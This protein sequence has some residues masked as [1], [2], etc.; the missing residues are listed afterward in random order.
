MGYLSWI[1]AWLKFCL[2]EYCTCP[3][4]SYSRQWCNCGLY[5]HENSFMT[6]NNKAEML[7]SHNLLRNHQCLDLLNPLRPSDLI[8]CFWFL[9]SLLQ[10]FWSLLPQVK[11]RC[12]MALS[13]Y[14]KQ[15]WHIINWTLEN[16]FY[17]NFNA[18][19]DIF[20][21]KYHLN[22]SSAKWQPFCFHCWDDTKPYFV[23]QYDTIT[24]WP[25]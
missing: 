6:Q 1:K 15:W 17:W 20:C 4:L 16:K 19:T 2:D 7:R 21:R 5:F 8:W 14:L 18:N 9:L 23:N 25:P 10:V 13:L 12:L 22:M 24:P 11:A 3:I